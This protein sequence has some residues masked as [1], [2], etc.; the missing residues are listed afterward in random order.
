MNTKYTIVIFVNR[1]I[2]TVQTTTDDS[3][4][5]HTYAWLI[6]GLRPAN[7]RR[8]YFVTTSLVGWVQ[9]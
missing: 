1:S 5:M 4:N 7:E 2:K 8:C 6:L 9:A 3:N